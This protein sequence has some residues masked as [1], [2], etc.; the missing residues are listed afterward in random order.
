MQSAHLPAGGTWL[1]TAVAMGQPHPTSLSLQ[2]LSTPG[3]SSRREARGPW[4]HTGLGA[5]PRGAASPGP[6]LGEQLG[7]ARATRGHYRPHPIGNSYLTP[8]HHQQPHPRGP[9]SLAQVGTPSQHPAATR[10][11][12]PAEGFCRDAAGAVAPARAPR[13]P[14]LTAEHSPG[15]ATEQDAAQ[16]PPAQSP[17]HHWGGTAQHPGDADGDGSLQP[18]PGTGQPGPQ[19]ELWC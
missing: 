7:M 12:H 11:P 19:G 18:C 2:L 8:T 9:P 6:S 16:H 4:P 15:G 1:A 14:K 3:Q 5:L 13:I 17:Q 10:S